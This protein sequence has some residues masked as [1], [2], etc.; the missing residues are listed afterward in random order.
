MYA[1]RRKIL[2]QTSDVWNNFLMFLIIWLIQI[3]HSSAG[4]LFNID[5]W[6]S[7][8]FGCC[9][10]TQHLLTNKKRNKKKKWTAFI[11]KLEFKKEYIDLDV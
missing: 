2:V 9:E 5:I 6:H 4:S 1:R 10:E 7:C 3:I 11:V 8:L